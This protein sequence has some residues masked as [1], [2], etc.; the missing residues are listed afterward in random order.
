MINK[1]AD[2]DAKDII[3][4]TPLYFSI[5]Y[6]NKSIMQLLLFKQCNPWSTKEINYNEA[7][8][9]NPDALLYLKK[10]RKIHILMTM[11]PLSKRQALWN[12]EGNILLL[13][14]DYIKLEIQRKNRQLAIELENVN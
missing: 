2:I 4:R 1:G 7:C 10:C 8:E 13:E 3:G 6:K 11:T 5:K 12:K 14:S 9:E